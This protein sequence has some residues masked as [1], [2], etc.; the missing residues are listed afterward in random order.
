MT[1]LSMS[2]CNS[3]HPVIFD[4]RKVILNDKSILICFFLPW[5]VSLSCFD[6]IIEYRTSSVVFMFFLVDDVY[7]ARILLA[8]VCR[9]VL[10]LL[11]NLILGQFH[12]R[13][14]HTWLWISL[15]WRFSFVTLLVWFKILGEFVVGFF[16]VGFTQIFIPRIFILLNTI[17]ILVRSSIISIFSYMSFRL[18]RII[19]SKFTNHTGL[20][21]SVLSFEVIYFLALGWLWCI[22]DC[23]TYV[24]H[25]YWI[26]VLGVQ[27]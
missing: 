27:I 20:L 16:L 10:W 7:W 12:K 3:H 5:N 18:P 4:I 2:I 6:S 9:H 22:K 21:S 19:I 24:C 13:S 8:L 11:R 17:C 23:G 26:L 25:D 14:V 1:L 15:I